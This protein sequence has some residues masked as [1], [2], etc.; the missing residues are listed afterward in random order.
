MYVDSYCERIAPGLWNEPLNAVS[1]V[2][3]LVAAAVLFALLARRPVPPPFSLW[4]PPA[5]TAVVGV[6]SWTF[7]MAAT[8]PTAALDSLSILLF[9]LVSVVV[10]IHWRWRVRW[11]WA[12]PAAPAFVAG[13]AAVN[14]VLFTVGGDRATLGGYLPALLALVGFGLAATRPPRP[15]PATAPPVG[16]A[17]GRILLTAAAVFAASLTFRTI[18]APICTAIPIGT[19]FL[20]HCLNAVVLFLVGYAIVRSHEPSA[21]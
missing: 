21:P 6:C 20:W 17:P 12:W 5:L 1:N 18:D 16:S 19:H 11:S 15:G 8:T 4:L 2:A 9:I 7:H 14:A 13:A 10:L 3:F